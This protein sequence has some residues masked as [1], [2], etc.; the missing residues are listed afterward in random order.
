MYKAHIE[1]NMLDED[2]AQ[3][4]AGESDWLQAQW[5]ECRRQAEDA[6]KNITGNPV[7]VKFTFLSTTQDGM[8]YDFEFNVP[9][10]N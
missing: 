9:T 4:L 3:W 6:G 10:S 5:P 2:T 1:A 7:F 8:L